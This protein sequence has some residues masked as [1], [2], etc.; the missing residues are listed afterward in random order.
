MAEKISMYIRLI[1]K[2]AQTMKK[3]DILLVCMITLSSIGISCSEKNSF[4]P[5]YYTLKIRF[6][7]KS[8]EDKVRGIDYVE[9]S[10]A[11]NNTYEI[12]KSVYKLEVTKTGKP[13]EDLNLGPLSLQKTDSNNCL[14]LTTSTLPSPD[15]HPQQL[16]HKLV[17]S[18]IFG[19]NDGHTITS[20]WEKKSTFTDLCT[21]IIVDGKTFIATETDE[22]GN[23][24]FVVVLDE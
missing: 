1:I 10:K 23:S 2:K 21:S 3:R 19:N 12:K 18:Y 14:V 7:D 11:E 17:C 22:Q 6:V 16:T 5:Y 8:G 9:N 13:G 20:N 15:Y 4:S 24:V